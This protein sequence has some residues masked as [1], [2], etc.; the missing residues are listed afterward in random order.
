[1]EGRNKAQMKVESCRSLPPISEQCACVSACV[2]AVHSTLA[3]VCAHAS[4][5][6]AST[7]G[8]NNNN[9]NCKASKHVFWFL[10]YI[11]ELVWRLR[12]FAVVEISTSFPVSVGRSIG[13]LV[14]WLVGWPTTHYYDNYR[15]N[16]TSKEAL[17]NN[18]TTVC[19]YKTITICP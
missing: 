16:S 11:C 18:T 14:G 1:M 3:N 12:Y 15:K 4:T 13:W 19:Y 5:G 7:A 2:P 10:F 6:A 9:N 8:D 17:A